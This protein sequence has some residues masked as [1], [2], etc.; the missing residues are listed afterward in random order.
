[1]AQIVDDVYFIDN[2][3][4]DECGERDRNFAWKKSQS[5]RNG[6]IGRREAKNGLNIL[7]SPFGRK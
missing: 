1:M 6:R 4:G 5:D 7:L 3:L 2:Y